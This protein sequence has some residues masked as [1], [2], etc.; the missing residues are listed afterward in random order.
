VGYDDISKQND[1]QKTSKRT[2]NFGRACNFLIKNCNF[3]IM[4]SEIL[5]YIYNKILKT[6]VRH[7]YFLQKAV[8]VLHDNYIV[9]T[10]LIP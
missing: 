9:Y 7:F 10:F 5:K 6:I 8:D 3:C 2:I 1:F 4:A